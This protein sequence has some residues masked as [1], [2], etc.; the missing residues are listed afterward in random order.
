MASLSRLYVADRLSLTAL[1]HAL[2]RV[3]RA[4]TCADLDAIAA[5]LLATP[6]S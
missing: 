5:D 3:L 2:E 6:T 4:R 1:E